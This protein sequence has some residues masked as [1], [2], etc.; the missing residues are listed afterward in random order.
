LFLLV[1]NYDQIINQKAFKDQKKNEISLAKDLTANNIVERGLI[2]KYLGAL[3][4]NNFQ[5]PRN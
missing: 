1:D 2:E 5:Q 3:D 4:L